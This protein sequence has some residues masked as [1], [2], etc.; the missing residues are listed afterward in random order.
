MS[1]LV[2][3]D[4][5]ISISNTT[6]DGQHRQLIDIINRLFT[7]M[8]ERKGDEVVLEC[9][10]ALH[11]YTLFHFREEVG[12]F[13]KSAYPK[14]EWHIQQHKFFLAKISEWGEQI[15]DGG[16]PLTVDMLDFTVKWLLNHIKVVDKEMGTYLNR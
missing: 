7:A 8:Q 13:S 11:D 15:I 9:Y 5:S 16:K 12:L 14:T 4:P 6:I 3:W 10:R 2:K 1:E